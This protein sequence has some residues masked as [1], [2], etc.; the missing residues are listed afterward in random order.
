MNYKVIKGALEQ[1]GDFILPQFALKSLEYKCYNN[2]CTVPVIKVD[3]YIK[4]NNK[5]VLCYFRHK[6]ETTCTRYNKD[7]VL[8]DLDIHREGIL[9]LKYILNNDKICKKIIRYC[10][11]FD[12]ENIVY[13]YEIDKK[14]IN[15]IIKD[16]FTFKYNCRNMR[17]D[18]AR[19]RNNEP[20][21]IYEILNTHITN[22]SNRPKNIPWFE[23]D[24]VQLNNQLESMVN[25]DDREI[26]LTCKRICT[27]CNECL[28]KKE[29]IKRQQRIKED[30]Y[31]QDLCAKICERREKEL[32]AKKEEK[33]EKERKDK[34][35]K[36]YRE[37]MELHMKL[38][39]QKYKEEKQKEQEEYE[40]RW[41]AG[42]EERE[43]KR[44]EQIIHNQELEKQ[45]IEKEKKVYTP[46]QY[47]KFKEYEELQ[48]KLNNNWNN[49]KM[50]I[51]NEEQKLGR[52]RIRMICMSKI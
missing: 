17:A 5:K 8:S 36:E 34:E 29:E 12:C 15:D 1:D 31:Y 24:A 32:I 33:E 6:S 4:K 27:I 26:T 18:V 28:I 13:E 37:K 11:V 38:S 7:R 45:R 50:P 16:E 19:V 42:K 25:F 23:I 14:E 21:E 52:E 43:R 22:E 10:Q 39:E 46:E 30:E 20:V 35:H 48:T 40:A 51:T 47:A 41:E 44:K 3:G 49:I 9:N 2:S